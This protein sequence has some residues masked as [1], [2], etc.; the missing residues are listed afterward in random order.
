[1]VLLT[2]VAVASVSHLSHRPSANDLRKERGLE[3]YRQADYEAAIRHFSLV[4]QTEP[5]SPD[6]FIA[7]G[8]VYER[9]GIAKAAEKE[10][11]KRLQT[12]K[13]AEARGLRLAG[14]F[15]GLGG[16]LNQAKLT[17]A[18]SDKLR[19]RSLTL[20]SQLNEFMRLAVADFE[21]A[22]NLVPEPDGRIF[23]CKAFCLAWHEYY[24][25]AVTHF[26]KAIQAGYAPA[27]VYA[28]L[29]YCYVRQG[30]LPK[31]REC[32]KQARLR[33]HDLGAIEANQRAID[34][35]D[36]VHPRGEVPPPSAC[37]VDPAEDFPF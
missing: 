33:S 5:N 12:Q 2:S 19:E 30:K 34:A 15:P 3:A 27:Q 9:L 24:H 10:A 35:P 21:G 23:A 8:R 17:Q 6:A 28:D 26:E 22:T 13:T 4:I 32:L 11:C 16:A 25:G 14:L 31:A 20:V 29:A 37:L 18:E 1:L 7:R 36:P